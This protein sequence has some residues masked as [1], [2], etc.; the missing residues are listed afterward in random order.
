MPFFLCAQPLGN[1]EQV[2]EEIDSRSLYA[3]PFPLDT[4]IDKVWHGLE[5]KVVGKALPHSV[6]L[7]LRTMEAMICNY[8]KRVA[9]S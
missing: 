4:N 9:P 2:A 7:I 5:R 1:P 6:S 3:R 8:P